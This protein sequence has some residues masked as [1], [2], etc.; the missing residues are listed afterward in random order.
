MQE[1][2]FKFNAEQV[3][4]ILAGLNE[5]P[6]KV[7]RG[8]SDFIVNTANE[9]IKATEEKATPDPAPAKKAK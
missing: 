6:Q 9:Q 5:L 8:L 7:S 2:N 4:I 1:L 3:N